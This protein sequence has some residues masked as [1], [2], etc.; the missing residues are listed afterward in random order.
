MPWGI[1]LFPIYACNFKCNYCIYS[2]PKENRGYNYKENM[3]SMEVLRKIVNDACSFDRKIKM[4]R[5]TGNGESLLHP[6]IDKMVSYIARKNIADN[7]EIITNGSL[8]TPDMSERLVAS[9]L[10]QIRISLQGICDEDYLKNSNVQIVFEQLV[11]NIKYL[12]EH[13]RNLKVNLKILDYTIDNEEKRNKFWNIFG[14]IADSISIEAVSPMATRVDYS[15]YGFSTNNSS[16]VKALRGFTIP[17]D[18][19]IC[20]HPFYLMLINP[21]GSVYPC[22]TFQTPPSMGN[23]MEENLND[24]WNGQRFNAFRR[25]MLNG[26][27]SAGEECRECQAFLHNMFM[28]DIITDEDARKLILKY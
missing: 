3:M 1:N 6:D 7:I 2:I 16:G 26:V 14:D 19:H 27:D 15:R 18:V 13:R 23:V 22:C 17:S 21:D 12:F 5:F 11:H 4:I 20:N 24:I 10:T 9:G 25:A 8:L 28:E